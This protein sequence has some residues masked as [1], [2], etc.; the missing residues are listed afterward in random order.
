MIRRSSK[1]AVCAVVLMSVSVHRAAAQGT[2]SRLH[3]SVT[4]AV[5]N[6]PL[7]GATL[8][9]TGDSLR[10]SLRTDDRGEFT[11]VL[12]AGLYELTTR[13][14]GYQVTVTPLRMFG[15]DSS[16]TIHL[17]PSAVALPR[18]DVSVHVPG[19]YGAVARYNDLQPLSGVRVQVIGSGKATETDSAG[20]YRIALP[21]PGTY[22]VRAAKSGYA[23][24]LLTVRVPDSTVEA[25]VLLDT[26]TVASTPEALL[27]EFDERLRWQAH[28]AAIVAGSELRRYGGTTTVA[29]GG[30]N[31]AI[32]RGLHLGPDICLF[33]NGVPRPYLPVDAIPVEAIE[34][35]ELYTTRGEVTSTLG[36][37]WPPGIQ[38]GDG[39]TKSNGKVAAGSDAST[40]RYVVI[41]LRR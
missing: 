34:N 4:D 31:D 8:S 24:Q 1:L 16:V 35:V 26:G 3:G 33:V 20:R 10:R 11:V 19:L 5:T 23:D 25:V 37:E 2:S 29:L 9:V 40:V 28:G 21:K 18:V 14:L 32:R 38:C 27:Q 36:H 41:W 12:P 39:R 17:A 30:A 15:R 7:A 22:V 13:R 6:R